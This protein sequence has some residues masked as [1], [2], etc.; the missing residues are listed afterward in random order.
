MAP[1]EEFVTKIH[2]VSHTHWDREWYLPFQLFRLKLVRLMDGLLDLMASDPQYRFFTLDGQTI[3]LDDYLELRPERAAEIRSLVQA[4]RL[5]IG[6]WRVL[7]DEFLVSPEAI[8]RNLLHGSSTAQRFGPTMKVGYI[9]DPFGH[10]GQMPQIL[11]GFGIDNA[12][13]QRGL[14]DEPCELWWQA[15][16]K[17]QV[18]LCNLREGYGNAALIP[19]EPAA[20]FTAEVRRLT[21]RLQAHSAVSHVLLMHGTDHTFPSP[22]T[23]QRIADANQE[24]REAEMVHSTLPD[25]IAA[26]KAD[27]A[28]RKD[29]LPVV[30]GELRSSKRWHLLPGVLSARTWIKQRNHNC[31]T[32]LEKWAEPFSLFASLLERLD[33]SPDGTTALRLMDPAPVLRRAWLLLLENHPHDS[34]CGCSIDQVHEEMRPRFDQVEQIGEEITRQSLDAL[35]QRVNRQPPDGIQGAFGAAVVFNAL[36]FPVS[37]TV[38]IQVSLPEALARVS[39]VDQYGRPCPFQLGEAITVE[40]AQMVLDREGFSNLVG[41][42]QSGRVSNIGPMEGMVLRQA[43]FEQDETSLQIHVELS[44]FGEPD[45]DSM[46]QAAVRVAAALQNPKINRFILQIVTRST[47]VRFRAQ[48]VPGLGFKTYW[49]LEKEESTPP[50][51]EGGDL[52]LENEFLRVELEQNQGSFKF[53]DKRS[54]TWFTGLNHFKDGGDCG[55]EYNYSPPENDEIIENGEVMEVRVERSPTGDSLLVHQVMHVPAELDEARTARSQKT[56]PVEIRTRATL[57]PDIPRLDFETE[58]SNSSRDHRLRVHFSAPIDAKYAAY[59]G[60]FEVVRR[61]LSAPDHDA[62]WAEAPRPE[63]PQRLFCDIS[64]GDTGLMVANRGL[65]EVEVR[66]LKAERTEIALTLLRCVGW[67]SRDD[68]AARQGHAGPSLATPGAQMQGTWRFQYALIPHAG[69]WRQVRSHAEAFNTPLR[70]VYSPIRPGSLP[71]SCSLLEVTPQSFS[72]SAIKEAEI[73]TGWIL[74]GVNQAEEEQTVIVKLGQFAAPTWRAALNEE[75]IDQAAGSGT[76]EISVPTRP[77]EIATLRIDWPDKIGQ[78]S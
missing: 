5:V 6:P 63:Q 34:I 42:L 22:L 28:G 78:A 45:P 31:E 19:M 7:P 2:L 36:A 35:A 55:D 11:R 47:R 27:I 70:T 67:L 20:A 58:I 72:V 65:R 10:I 44:P 48:D 40:L 69:D 33:S 68:F 8:V 53:L 30:L 14:S 39:V 73:G 41:A 49:F 71:S 77:K 50:P 37:E 43:E 61:E 13:L 12:C 59:D 74:R 54:G 18:L 57:A 4:G 15:P 29:P 16:D 32:L 21:A 3:V 26:V 17:S 23:P 66:T 60:H 1:G 38:D 75:V 64:R 25:Y 52:V 9:P 24:L 51:S 56:L 62:S 76:G 46:N